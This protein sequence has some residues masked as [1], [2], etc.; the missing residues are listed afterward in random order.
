MGKDFFRTYDVHL[1]AAIQQSTGLEPQ[2]DIYRG[3]LFFLFSNSDAVNEAILSFTSNQPLIEYTRILR[4][5]KGIITD[6]KRASLNG[7]AIGA[8]VNVR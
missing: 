5:L 2:I 7:Q 3:K 1:S 6:H 4:R 8:A